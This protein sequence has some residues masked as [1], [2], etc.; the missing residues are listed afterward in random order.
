MN[1]NRKADAT[2]IGSKTKHLNGRSK[3]FSIL[4][5]SHDEQTPQSLRIYE[6]TRRPNLWRIMDHARILLLQSDRRR[7]RG[8]LSLI[9]RIANGGK[10]DD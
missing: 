7:S 6:V 8:Q 5:L 1:K 9:S 4:R 2:N 10:N 3:A